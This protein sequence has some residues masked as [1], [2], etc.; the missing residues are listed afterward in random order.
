MADTE[1]LA[2]TPPAS[3]M[4]C[5]FLPLETVATITDTDDVEA[6]GGADRDATGEFAGVGPTCRVKVNGEDR[7]VVRVRAYWAEGIG[8]SNF[9]SGL[10]DDRYNQLPEE[11]GLGFSWTEE[12]GSSGNAS[13]KSAEARLLYG[14]RLIEVRV[15]QVVEGR[16]PEADAIAVA[17]QVI[18]TLELDDEWTL[19]GDPPSR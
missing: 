9:E 7:D 17:Q 2:P 8:K 18:E 4:L 15:A 6:R 16:D 10:T 19:P 12:N 14:D 11:T 1:E 5:D 3:E 13:N